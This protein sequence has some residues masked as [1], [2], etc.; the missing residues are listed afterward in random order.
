MVFKVFRNVAGSAA[1]AP[2]ALCTH[3]LA[4][5]P[6]FRLLSLTVRFIAHV[7]SCSARAGTPAPIAVATGGAN[8]GTMLTLI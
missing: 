3:Q 5:V 1:R 6:L 7:K 4:R 8:D 2:R